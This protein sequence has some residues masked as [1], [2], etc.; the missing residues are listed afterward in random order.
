MNVY[1]NNDFQIM[2]LTYIITTFVGVNVFVL[3]YYALNSFI[4]FILLLLI[5]LKISNMKSIFELR[6]YLV[7]LEKK[8]ESEMGIGPLWE[9]KITQSKHHIR[10][11]ASL[12]NIIYIGILF[13]MII[14]CLITGYKYNKL[15]GIIGFL[16]CFV[17]T[18]IIGIS[19]I[20]LVRSYNDIAHSSTKQEKK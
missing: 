6:K 10:I 1:E 15:I 2:N 3:K 18:I 4:P 7:I 17:M 19:L 9:E 20:N 16:S 8:I 11:E 14:Y 5:A 13:L 12:V